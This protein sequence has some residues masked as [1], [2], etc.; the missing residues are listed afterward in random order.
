MLDGGAELRVV[1]ELLGHASA[2]TTQIYTHVTEEQ[3]RRVYTE[4][5]YKQ[6]LL[7][8]RKEQSDD[9]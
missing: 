1:Q 2:N 8:A 9:N 4:A 5:F 7:K 3:Q 6:V